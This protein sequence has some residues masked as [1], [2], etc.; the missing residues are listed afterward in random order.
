MSR[1]G[2]LLAEESAKSQFLVITLKPEMVSK[3]ERVYGVY[4]RNGVS[5][6]I[7]TTLKEAA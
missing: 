4:E 6:V 3:A 5:H 2:E 1:L 7:S